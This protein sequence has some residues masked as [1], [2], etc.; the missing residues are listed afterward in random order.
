[1]APLKEELAKE[2]LKGEYPCVHF[3]SLFFLSYGPHCTTIH[4]FVKH[5]F[6]R[7]SIGSFVK[8]LGLDLPA[9]HH[10]DPGQQPPQ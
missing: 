7:L 9:Q 10:F 3:D 6:W 1:M 2:K 8:L 5:D 4:R